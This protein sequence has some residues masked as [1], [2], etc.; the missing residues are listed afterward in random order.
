MGDVPD[1][2]IVCPLCRRYREQCGA[3]GSY[4]CQVYALRGAEMP[5]ETIARLVSYVVHYSNVTLKLAKEVAKLAAPAPA[6]C[7]W[8]SEGF[9]GPEARDRVRDHVAQC[10]K[11]PLVL[12][13]AELHIV[14]VN[15]LP[16]PGND[17][18]DNLRMSTKAVNRALDL[19]AQPI[20]SGPRQ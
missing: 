5:A 11:N 15:G 4:S 20:T 2:Q 19:L 14:L 17:V 8:C 1:P 9:E 12:K 3:Y 10:A 7:G 16:V 18:D 13:L 6:K